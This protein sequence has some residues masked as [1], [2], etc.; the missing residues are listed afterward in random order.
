MAKP[1]PP[2]LGIDLGGTSFLVIAI[3]ERGRQIAEASRKTRPEKGFKG[4][5]NR[6][7]ETSEEVIAKV[8]RRPSAVCVGVPGARDPKKGVVVG[9]PNLGWK[10]E[11]L[12]KKLAKELKT[13]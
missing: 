12:A 10:E 6:L 11:P 2:V 7:V 8:G 4:V 9:A 5:L 1:R 13:R 3:D